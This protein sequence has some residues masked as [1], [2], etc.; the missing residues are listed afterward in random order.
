MPVLEFQLLKTHVPWPRG[1]TSNF[2]MKIN[3]AIVIDFEKFL[4]EGK[5]DCLKLG[6]SKEWVLGNFPNPD[7]FDKYPNMIHDDIWRYGVIEL[8]F[9]KNEL[10]LIFSD[11]VDELNGGDSLI[12]EK[13]ILSNTKEFRLSDIMSK[14][15]NNHIDF[16]KN[17]TY[18]GEAMVK[19]EL[20][21]Q[22]CLSFRLEEL[23]AEEYEKYIKRSKVV[24]QNEFRLSSFS[25]M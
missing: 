7:G 22:V 11:Y 8:H 6:Q 21:S 23:E 12:L 10:F 2:C 19:L 14:L 9:N 1:V 5:F 25:L 18:F 13:H 17:T 15:N 20:K 3:S 16:Q 4:K 24:S